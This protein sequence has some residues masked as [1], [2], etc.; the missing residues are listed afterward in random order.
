MQSQNNI[1]KT[2]LGFAPVSAAHKNVVGIL[3]S[4][5]RV[6]VNNLDGCKKRVWQKAMLG[7]NTTYINVTCHPVG[8]IVPANFFE[9]PFHCFVL[10]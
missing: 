3:S 2:L 4:Q 9:A 8:R 10:Q 7:L 6:I 1:A 5:K